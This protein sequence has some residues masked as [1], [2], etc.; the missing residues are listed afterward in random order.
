MGIVESVRAVRRARKP[1]GG[2]V[3]YL[4]GEHVLPRLRS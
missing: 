4:N 3:A 1:Q 2:Q